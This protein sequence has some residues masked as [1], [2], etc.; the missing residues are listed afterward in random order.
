MLVSSG[1]QEDFPVL[2]FLCHL[3]LRRVKVQLQATSMI[4]CVTF[5]VLLFF[6]FGRMRVGGAEKNK[7]FEN[8]RSC[9]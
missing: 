1:T 6:S 4:C 3:Q 5:E 9:V 8:R 2:L 7:Y